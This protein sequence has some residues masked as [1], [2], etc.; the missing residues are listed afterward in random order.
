[1]K[2]DLGPLG[3]IDLLTSGEL[4]EAIGHRLDSYV[5]DWVRGIKVIRLPV[6]YGE[7]DS[8]GNILPVVIPGPESGYVWDVR[9][10]TVTG[11]GIYGGAGGVFVNL[12]RGNTA[13]DNV[14]TNLL[15]NLTGQSGAT[16]FPKLS[17][18][19]FPGEGLVISGGNGGDSDPFY[20][21]GQVTEVPAEMV[22]KL[23]LCNPGGQGA[24]YWYRGYLGA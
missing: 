13:A 18:T 23:V 3:Q 15:A 9:R 1:V 6:T 14:D 24:G 10:I 4:K 2:Q 12:Y 19:L 5:R 20:V 16:I 7:T 8:G 22:G 17:V 21:T 11:P